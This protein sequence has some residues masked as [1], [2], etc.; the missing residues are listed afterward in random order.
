MKVSLLTDF[1]E[2][3]LRLAYWKAKIHSSLREV[4]L[5][6][7][8]NQLA[9]GDINEASVY[10]KNLLPAF[11]APAF[12]IILQENDLSKDLVVFCYKTQ[13]IV[14]ANN[15]LPF[16]VMDDQQPETLYKIS[17]ESETAIESIIN[18]YKN[19]LQDEEKIAEHYSEISTPV[20]KIPLKPIPQSGQIQANIVLIQN[21][22]LLLTNILKNSFYQSII[23]DQFELMIDRFDPIV[24]SS[25]FSS[26]S[27]D[28]YSFNDAEYLQLH[29]SESTSKEIPFYYYQ[30][31][32]LKAK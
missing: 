15:G 30:S 21:K 18:C 7:L 2:G 13:Y 14:C 3:S 6:E 31:I 8:S 19:L 28:H 5:V 27:L 32:K 22:Q 24:F 16:L 11:D 26:S 1:G 9:S 10:I 4:Q 25:E 12:H 23:S 17:Q 20:Q 29:L